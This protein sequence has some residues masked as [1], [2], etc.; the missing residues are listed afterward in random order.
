MREFVYISDRKVGQFLPD[1]R[2]KREWFRRHIKMGIQTPLGS[3]S[4][5]L[6]ERTSQLDRE[7]Q[8][9]RIIDHVEVEAQW[10]ESRSVVTG[11][12]IFFDALM[13]YG[14]VAGSDA[15]SVVVFIDANRRDVR[16]LLHGSSEHLAGPLANVPEPGWRS[17]S[18]GSLFLEMIP[19]VMERNNPLDVEESTEP[20]RIELSSGYGGVIKSMVDM[21]D[22]LLVAPPSWLAGYARVTAQDPLVQ[23]AGS[24]T[25][26]ASPLFVER[27][28]PPQS[29]EGRIE[30]HGR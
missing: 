25:V 14:V 18:E 21:L 23:T 15:S 6:P 19:G 30:F 22:D 1:P 9:R 24:W 2:G 3:L 13:R 11:Q 12:W 20:G 8:L 5:E 26:L 29:D 17:P 10:Y 4:A 7:V 28:P 27:V 16:L